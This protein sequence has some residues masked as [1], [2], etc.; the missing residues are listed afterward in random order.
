VD[1]LDLALQ[2]CVVLFMVAGL[3]GAGL[4]VAPAAAIAQLRDRQFVL[5]TLIG[6]WLLSPAA[7]LLLL[8]LIPLERPYATALL[9]LALAPCAPFAPARVRTAHG[10][11]ACMAA[12]VVLAAG[13]TVLVMPVAVPLMLAGNVGPWAVAR[14]LVLFVLLPL[15]AGTALRG[16]RPQAADRARRPLDVAAQAATVGLM[17]LIG[18]IHGRGMVDAVGS[19]AIAVQAL[20][21]TAVTAGADW[22]GAGL[23]HGQRSVLTIG[24]STRNLGAALAPLAAVDPDPRAIVMIALAVPLTVAASAVVAR[25]LA[26]RAAPETA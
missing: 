24:L 1:V 11:S 26:W 17:I 13:G 22:L 7:A 21:I 10:D 12:F 20:F 4:G 8:A 5:R 3:A 15:L 25:M 9:L 23:P 19:H 6:G 18:V 16:L 2:A 14:P